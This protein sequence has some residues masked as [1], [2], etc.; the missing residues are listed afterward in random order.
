MQK[1]SYILIVCTFPL[2]PACTSAI[3]PSADE[4]PV[5]LPT[6]TTV[7]QALWEHQSPDQLSQV[8]QSINHEGQASFTFVVS[9]S[10]RVLAITNQ[11]VLPVN[12][13]I[14]TLTNLLKKSRFA[15]VYKYSVPLE[16]YQSYTFYY[17]DMAY[18]EYWRETCEHEGNRDRP[19]VQTGI[20]STYPHFCARIAYP[21]FTAYRFLLWPTPA[22]CKKLERLECGTGK[23]VVT[24]QLTSNGHTRDVSVVKSDAQD[25]IDLAA[26]SCVRNWYFVAKPSMQL[27]TSKKYSLT[28]IYQ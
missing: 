9:K 19:L 26:E 13:D 4:Q 17:G 21:Q 6:D 7:Y 16:S 23:V 1:W 25:L 28:L 5:P 24:F 12:A 20:D 14:S 27:S 18:L 2:L 11:H 22:A 8:S 10:G 15:P 3:R